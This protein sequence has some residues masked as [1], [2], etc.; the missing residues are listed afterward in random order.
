MGRFVSRGDVVWVKPNI[1]WNRRP[2]QAATTNPDVVATL[3][4]LC[5]EAGAKQGDRERQLLQSGAG[6]V[7]A[8]RNP[9]GGAEGRR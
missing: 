8:Q 3:V 5:F 6:L 1:G 2:E 7:C 4:A 9:A